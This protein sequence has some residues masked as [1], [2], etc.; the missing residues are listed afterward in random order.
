[1]LL[2][3]NG[4]NQG[5]K[6]SPDQHTGKGAT[7]ASVGAAGVLKKETALCALFACGPLR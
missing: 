5:S 6:G 4:S 3:G 1:M 2:R 7:R